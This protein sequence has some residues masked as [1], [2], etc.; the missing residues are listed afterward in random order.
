MTV[1]YDGK[2]RPLIGGMRSSRTEHPN[3]L[4]GCLWQNNSTWLRNGPEFIGISLHLSNEQWQRFHGEYFASIDRKYGCT[5]P[6]SYYSLAGKLNLIATG[7][8][9]KF[10]RESTGNT[11][12]GIVISKASMMYL[13]RFSLVEPSAK[14]D[15]LVEI[16][17][18][19]FKES[20]MSLKRAL[21]EFIDDTNRWY[22]DQR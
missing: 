20:P 6:E 15:E 17:S 11:V 2:I 22:E 5:V 18:Q 13:P 3:Q 16:H 14:L 21:A 8:F 19:G 9:K 4:Y 1:E 12:S 7:Q 10:V